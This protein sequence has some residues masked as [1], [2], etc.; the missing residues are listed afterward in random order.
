MT[1]GIEKLPNGNG[2]L[3]KSPAGRPAG[4][5]SML[6]KKR[7]PGEK[8]PSHGPFTAPVK[9][10][11][12]S[13]GVRPLAEDVAGAGGLGRPGMVAEGGVPP[14][15]RQVFIFGAYRLFFD[16]L[17]SRMP[18]ARIRCSGTTS[19]DLLS[20]INVLP[21]FSLVNVSPPFYLH[22]Q[23]LRGISL[24][25]LLLLSHFDLTVT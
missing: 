18:R 8:S 9:E 22:V 17:L 10:K 19:D 7:K 15:A 24:S 23:N 16:R 6:T 1:K 25:P 12:A 14:P 5:V 2:A 20:L 11:S 3:P 21:P 4:M 13:H